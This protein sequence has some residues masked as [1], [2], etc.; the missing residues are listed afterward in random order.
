MT[1]EEWFEQ[2]YGSKPDLDNELAFIDQVAKA[3]WDA[4][5]RQAYFE[6]T[7]NWG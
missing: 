3:A 4:G 6:C 5:H 7:P 2:E 1:F